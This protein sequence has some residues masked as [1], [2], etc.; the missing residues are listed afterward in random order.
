MLSNING[1]YSTDPKDDEEIKLISDVTDIDENIEKMIG[2]SI[3]DYG[4]GGMKTKI[5][6]AKTALSAGCH[7]AITHGLIL[8]KHLS[9]QENNGL[10]EQ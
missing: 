1:L 4:K 3:S 9:L 6:A 8:Q 10:L 2:S 7:L 5:L